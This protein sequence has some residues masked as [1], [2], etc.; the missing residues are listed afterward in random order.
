MAPHDGNVLE[1][2]SKTD[3]DIPKVISDMF[4]IRIPSQAKHSAANVRL[5]DFLPAVYGSSIVSARELI[6]ISGADF[7]IDK[8]YM[9]I[10]EHY[11]KFVE[12][13]EFREVYDVIVDMYEHKTDVDATGDPV[14]IVVV[15]VVVIVAVV[16]VLVVVVVVV[17]IIVDTVVLV[18]CCRFRY[19]CCCCFVVAVVVV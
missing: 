2:I 7:D 14:D 3:A 12:T 1:D 17:V 13:G 4:G 18:L 11:S 16:V 5:V 15:A 9:H 8:L 6:E 10:K 19:Y